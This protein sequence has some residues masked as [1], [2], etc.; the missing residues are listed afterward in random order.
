MCMVGII[1]YY[2]QKPIMSLI[3]FIVTAFVTVVIA[4]I[5]FIKLYR[6]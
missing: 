2:T 5:V 4:V 1:E 6:K 3:I